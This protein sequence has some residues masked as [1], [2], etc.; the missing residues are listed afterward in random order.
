MTF[1]HDLA[2]LIAGMRA[3]GTRGRRFDGV[4]RGGHLPDHDEWLETCFRQNQDLLEVPL[5]RRI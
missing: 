2:Q 5:L 1:A 4:G 3:A